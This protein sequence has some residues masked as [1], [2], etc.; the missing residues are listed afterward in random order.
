MIFYAVQRSDGLYY[1]P[2]KPGNRKDP[3]FHKTPKL[4]RRKIHALKTKEFCE[5]GINNHWLP[6]RTFTPVNVDV[7]VFTIT[8]EP[9]N[10]QDMHM[11]ER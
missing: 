11:S 6:S 4:Y 2:N 1:N 9:T 7:V 3:T 10:E 8:K 5:S